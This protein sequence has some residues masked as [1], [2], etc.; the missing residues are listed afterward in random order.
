M[1]KYILAT[2]M[3]M[4]GIV[5]GHAMKA[6]AGVMVSAQAEQ[7]SPFDLMKNASNLPVEATDQPF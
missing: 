5:V 6:P 7:V 2:A 3:F 1:S 4:L